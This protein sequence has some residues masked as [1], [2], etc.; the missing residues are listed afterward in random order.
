MTKP[1]RFYILFIIYIRQSYCC[2]VLFSF[3]H[4]FRITEAPLNNGL[5]FPLKMIFLLHI[6][7]HS[8]G[9]HLIF[10]SCD[11]QVVLIIAAV[12]CGFSHFVILHC[13]AE[14]HLNTLYIY[15]VLI[16]F[17]RWQYCVVHHVTGQV[18]LWDLYVG[19]SLLVSC[20]MKGCN[21]KCPII[22]W[23]ELLK[24]PLERDLV[25]FLSFY[26][27]FGP[28]LI[29]ALTFLDVCALFSH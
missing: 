8:D 2:G 25:C 3:H 22:W 28:A 17:F 9:S 12:H 11:S 19:V 18:T 15:I 29:V 13:I 14:C 16:D 23:D 26:F 5:Y 24:W 6:T 10:Q 21:L 20:L 4:L 1:T 27:C 7:C